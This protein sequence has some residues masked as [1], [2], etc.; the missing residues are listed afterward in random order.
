M[1]GSDA[2]AE[3]DDTGRPH[4][5]RVYDWLLGGS[6]NH[7][8][9]RALAEQMLRV[10]PTAAYSARTNRAFM[11]RATRLL[12]GEG[13]RQFLDIGSGI[14]T[15]PNLHQTARAVAPDSRVVYV[16]HDPLVL[17]QSAALLAGTPEGTTHYVDADAREPEH[18]VAAAREFLD[19]RRPVALSLNALLHFIP[20]E[21][22]HPLVRSLVGALAPGSALVLSHGTGD[23]DPE[24]EAEVRR[25]YAAGGVT[26][27]ARSH[28]E[29]ARFFEGLELV[30]PGLVLPTEWRPDDATELPDRDVVV[31]GY[32]GV[33]YKR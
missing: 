26:L 14:P 12:A 5:A 20:D 25:L 6:D 4:P 10:H 19:F 17:R 3:R 33:A 7:P 13:I 18:V 30:E 8:V 16:D 32:A 15:E 11:H 31:P 24:A 22:A 23:F 29:I 9:D 1:T 27:R 28:A 21:D 2:T